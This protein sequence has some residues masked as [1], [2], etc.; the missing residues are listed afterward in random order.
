MKNH[1]KWPPYHKHKVGDGLHYINQSFKVYPDGTFQYGDTSE[2][3]VIYHASNM[4]NTYDIPQFYKIWSEMYP[5]DPMT[6]T[7]QAY[8]IAAAWDYIE[9]T[10]YR[11]PDNRADV[12]KDLRE[13]GYPELADRITKYLE[14]KGVL[15]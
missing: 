8:I 9:W 11:I 5:K 2:G 3:C 4:C 10:D 15:V 13:V 12:I 14:E 6:L 7:E 1:K